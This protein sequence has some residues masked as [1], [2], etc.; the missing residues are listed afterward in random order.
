CEDTCV[1]INAV[2]IVAPGVASGDDDDV[3]IP[4]ADKPPALVPFV[5]PV[6]DG[7]HGEYAARHRPKYSGGFN[8]A[9]DGVRRGGEFRIKVDYRDRLIL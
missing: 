5:L 2:A 8:G 4:P 6:L 3:V 9:P 7:R 1:D